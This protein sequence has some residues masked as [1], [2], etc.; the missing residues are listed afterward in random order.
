MGATDLVE[1]IKRTPLIV[2]KFIKRKNGTSP[3]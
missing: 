3:N 2:P 1:G